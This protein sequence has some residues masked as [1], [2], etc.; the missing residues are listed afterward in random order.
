MYCREHDSCAVTAMGV[1]NI[2]SCVESQ[3][4]ESA[5]RFIQAA[6]RI[7]NQRHS[8]GKSNFRQMH[9]KHHYRR[10]T[11]IVSSKCY[12]I[13]VY[14]SRPKEKQNNNMSML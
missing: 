2:E 5:N 14:S 3:S 4:V 6:I 13:R 8:H 10:G 11:L 12:G 7:T 1:L 9:F